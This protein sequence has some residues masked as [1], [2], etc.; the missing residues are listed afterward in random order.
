[1]KESLFATFV[2]FKGNLLLEVMVIPTNN[3]SSFFFTLTD[4][5]GLEAAHT[6]TALPVCSTYVLS[7]LGN[8]S[9][10][11]TVQSVPSLHSSL[12]LSKLSVA[13][14]G[15]SASTLPSVAA[16]FL[17]GQRKAAAATC[18]LQLFFIHT[19]S[20]TDSAVLL[21]VAFDCCVAIRE[22][23]RSATILTTKCM[24][25]IGLPIVPCSAALHLPLPTLHG[26]LR[27]QPVNT[28]SHSHCGHPDALRLAHAGTRATAASGSL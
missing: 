21:A 2:C 11:H 16:V 12:F 13:D 9:I 18:F 22:P 27:F 7:L 10:T 19:F 15:L 17:L 5:P 3:A 6:R 24:G 4:L 28:L 8:I 23:L 25:A 20:G 14:L 26:R 1:M